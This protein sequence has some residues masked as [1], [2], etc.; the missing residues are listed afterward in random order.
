[1]GQQV[2]EI[3]IDAEGRRLFV[4][5]VLRDLRALERMI[6]DGIVESGVRRIGTEQE[7]VFVDAEW[8]PAPVA[9]PVLERLE[10]DNFTTELSRFN[11]EINRP[12]LELGGN[13]MSRLERGLRSDLEQVRH[14]AAELGARPVLT[15][16]LPTLRKADL[17]IENITP[18]PR[19]TLLA[20]ALRRLRGGPYEFRFT[21]CDELIMQ[22]ESVLLEAGA[23]SCQ[24]HLQV[25]PDE[26]ATMYNTAQAVAGPLMA[27]AV[28]S[29]LLF[30]RR[31]WRETR[32]GLF[33]QAVDT[34]RPHEECEN[35][36]A[37][38]RFG[39]GWVRESATELFRDDIA[40]FPVVIAKLSEE[41]PFEMLARGETPKLKA[42]QLFNGTV[43]RWTRACYGVTAG[44]PHLRIENRVLP[45]GPSLVDEVANGAFW[46]GLMFGVS[47]CYGDMAR[48]LAFD[49]AKRNFLRACRLGLEA[50]CTWPGEGVICAAQLIDHVLLP[51]AREGLA[52][53]GLDPAEIDRYIGVIEQRVRTGRT[54]ARW[55]LDSFERLRDR[56]PI[57]QTLRA[58]VA[59]TWQRQQEGRPVHEWSSAR[60][61]ESG[62]RAESFLRV[63][64]IMT[65]DV[66]TVSEDDVIDLAASLMDW[67]H[68]RHVPVEDSERRLV[69]LISYR[70]L[71]RFLAQDLPHGKKHPVAA[72][73]VMQRDPITVAPDTTTLEA[74]HLMRERQVP[75]LPVVRGNRLVGILTERDFIAVAA[76]LLEE[77]LRQA[78]PAPGKRVESTLAARAPS[79]VAVE[80]PITP[81]E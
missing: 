60:H 8:Q 62:S 50:H 54:G 15:G 11:I 25:G 63:D 66:F 79:D 42:L 14:V 67:K 35:R 44:R 41:E 37:R 45:S 52:D 26:F 4:K 72:R 20:D 32:I 3:L 6:D 2:E 73:D 13:C 81:K 48:R 68:I 31:L 21:G 27:A 47:K 58:I 33:Q 49:D 30:G 55:M 9:M 17:D 38:V 16:I 22:H 64:Q 71:L 34:R 43:Y 51:L 53:V 78:H 19:Y 10:G 57:P 40:R 76:E 61:E 46:Y 5:Q 24:F 69:G 74:M 12:P 7:L 29:P 59:A 77:R 75:C 39:E 23:T 56:C 70:Q 65:T 80:E 18:R 36:A 28:N 1:V